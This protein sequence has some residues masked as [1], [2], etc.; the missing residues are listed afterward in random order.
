MSCRF[1]TPRKRPISRGAFWPGPTALIP[2]SP[3][4]PTPGPH[5]GLGTAS[6]HSLP[7]MGSR[8]S[9]H[10]LPAMP[11]AGRTAAMINVGEPMDESAMLPTDDPS[12]EP[13]DES[14]MLARTDI[15]KP[16]PLPVRPPSSHDSHA[17]I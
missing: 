7:A 10:N 15:V 12:V 11:A 5:A 2:K 16:P 3:L 9:F 1:P 8:G 14:G 6:R 17:V 4:R 13:Q